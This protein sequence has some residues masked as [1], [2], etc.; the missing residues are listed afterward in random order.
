MV[1][2][3]QNVDAYGRNLLPRT[4]LTALFEAIL[5]VPGILRYRFTI[6]HPRYK[7]ECL[8]RNV[9]ALPTFANHF[10]LPFPAGDN[11][12]LRRISHDYTFERYERI[13]RL[14]RQGMPD[15][16]VTAVPIVAFP[17][18]KE[19]QFEKTLALMQ[20]LTLDTVHTAA[21]SARPNTP[22]GVW[23]DQ[24]AEAVK[25]D[26]LTCINRQVTRDAPKASERR[27]GT[28]SAVL[29]EGPNP[30]V[31]GEGCGRNAQN[32]MVY[33][34]DD[35][36][37]CAARIVSVR[38]TVFLHSFRPLFLIVLRTLGH[39]SCPIVSFSARDRGLIE[40]V[41]RG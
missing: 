19:E 39:G 8:I 26:R 36:A 3:C 10:H 32:T 20:R 14:I 18:G 25:E 23:E 35:A 7:T 13:V 33:F 16:F 24:L 21:Y 6:S 41:R 27:V 34:E 28:I 30:L 22:A 37:E 2:L 15:A 11:T 29:V 9:A 31:Q 40:G 4:N 1:L 17:G 12:V 5:D 38:I